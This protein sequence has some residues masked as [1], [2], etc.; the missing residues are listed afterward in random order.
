[1]EEILE[2][3]SQIRG[4]ISLQVHMGNLDVHAG[5]VYKEGSELV[6]AITSIKKM[7]GVEKI[8][9]SEQALAHP[10]PNR[11]TELL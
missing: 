10:L 7:K 2:K 4:I 1:M 5:L 9:W 6:K 3:I 8:V 11:I